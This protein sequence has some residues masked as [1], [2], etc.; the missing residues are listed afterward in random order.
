[1]DPR[2][3]IRNIAFLDP[4]DPGYR[5]FV[6]ESRLANMRIRES[7]GNRAYPD[8]ISE[9]FELAVREWLKPVGGTEKRILSYERLDRSQKYI[10]RFRELDFVIDDGDCIYLGELKVS[11]STSLLRRAYRQLSEA[12]D[13]LGRTGKKVRAV[14]IFINLSHE[15][16][17]TTVNTFD[18]D[19]TKV[20]FMHRSV[21]GRA[22]EFL[23]LSPVEIFQ[24]AFENAIISESGLLELALNEA[25]NRQSDRASRRDLRSR[26]VPDSEGPPHL[27]EKKSSGKIY[28]YGRNRTAESQIAFRLKEA[29]GKRNA[30]I[31]RIGTIKA[32]DHDQGM[33]EVRTLSSGNLLFN[34]ESFGSDP[35]IRPERGMV[36]A[37]KRKRVTE[38]GQ[39]SL[40]GCRILDSIDDFELL[41]SLL[42]LEASPNSQRIMDRKG[43]LSGGISGEMLKQTTL[44]IFAGKGEQR[45][46]DTVLHYYDRLLLDDHF[47]HFC[48][49]IENIALP[50]I[51][52]DDRD[53]LEQTLYCHFFANIR[54]D[55]L[56]Q[57]WKHSAFRYIAYTDGV[58][59]EIPIEIILQNREQLDG[60]HWERI[61][62]Y[63]YAKSIQR[64]L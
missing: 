5:K 39:F 11:F 34:V 6:E 7:R 24:W 64:P 47:V 20:E 57:V 21:N 2:T 33:G 10:K 14:L 28:R 60:A 41:M 52:T 62:Q 63:S 56:F 19:F 38:G 25:R 27:R 8:L 48:S 43:F 40:E 30:R 42:M 35:S 44:Q 53:M 37:Y 13:V 1:M 61:A 12:I 31:S 45:F 58:D 18:P 15:N 55:V 50:L 17:R 59:Y 4:S 26:N 49:Y 36:I 9:Q 32:F 3:K 16:A 22:Y 54:P 29:L 51:E 23:H 46:M